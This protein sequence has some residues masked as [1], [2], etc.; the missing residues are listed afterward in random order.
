MS[1][2]IVIDSSDEDDKPLTKNN[3]DVK[4][5]AA[6][7]IK[8]GKDKTVE[9]LNNH[10]E[11][12]LQFVD[13]CNKVVGE[14]EEGRKIILFLN[15]KYE[16]SSLDYKNSREFRKLLQRYIL[17]LD[18][19][20]KDVFVLVHDVVSMLDKSNKAGSEIKKEFPK[21]KPSEKGFN[22]NDLA[23]KKRRVNI[24]SICKDLS[25]KVVSDDGLRCEIKSTVSSSSSGV[26]VKSKEPSNNTEAGTSST[27]DERTSHLRRKRKKKIKNLENLLKR[28]SNEIIRLQNTELSLD[29]LEKSDTS[30]IVESKLKKRFM[31]IYTQLCKI[32]K[33]PV[34]TGRV[35]EKKIKVQSSRFVEINQK[36][37]RYINNPRRG[38][39]FPD[40]GDIYHLVEQANIK[41]NLCL[42]E[43]HIEINAKE[44]FKEVGERLQKRREKDFVFEFGCSSIDDNKNNPDPA[45]SD[46]I[47]GKK[48]T[49]NR[50][51]AK[52]NMKTVIDKYSKLQNDM[53]ERSQQNEDN[54]KLDDESDDSESDESNDSKTIQIDSDSSET[55]LDTNIGNGGAK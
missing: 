42:T 17:K 4:K 10:D 23:S 20:S 49:E 55:D 43:C 27:E 7:I 2:I 39:E 48:L 37:A 14:K 47:L 40:Y 25:E 5:P 46:E 16:E 18:N 12:F 54:G 34:Q 1:Q 8:N 41:N 29:D 33:A 3:E 11:F 51:L 15:K 22:K 28:I 53:G 31:Q 44:V 13:L 45:L 9:K 50:T 24:E 30:Y 36:V 6:E 38:N 35:I 52:D 26:D 21:R 19:G 32:N